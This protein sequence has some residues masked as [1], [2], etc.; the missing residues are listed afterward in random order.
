MESKPKTSKSGLV[1]KINKVKGYDAGGV[2]NPQL[3]AQ[4]KNQKTYQNQNA[5]NAG[6]AL[7]GSVGTFVNAANTPDASGNIS[8]NQ[9]ALGTSLQDASAGAS[10]GASLG[11]FGGPLGTLIGGG[12]G[13]LGGG[14]YGA[15]KGYG[16]ANDANSEAAKLVKEQADA[17]KKTAFNSN[18]ANQFSSRNLYSKGG[19]V[20]GKGTGTSDSIKAKVAPGSFIVPAKNAKKAK[21][22]KE[23]ILG[24]DTD[25]KAELN[26]KN[27]TD[28]RISHGEYV[29]SPEEK[30]ELEANGINL[31]MLAPDAEHEN[32]EMNK[33]G[34]SPEKA[35]LILKD[36]TIRGKSITDKQR[37]YF[38]WV[39]GGKKDGGVIEEYADGG[40]VGD[41]TGTNAQNIKRIKTLRKYKQQ[42]L[43]G[44][45][46]ESPTLVKSAI[47][48][49]DDELNGIYSSYKDYKFN[50]E[51]TYLDEKPQSITS[52]GLVNKVSKTTPTTAQSSL[53]KT[54]VNQETDNSVVVPPIT[55]VTKPTV[56][57]NAIDE[58]GKFDTD[59]AAAEAANPVATKPNYT[60][61]I[62]SGLSSLVN[63]GVPLLQAGLGYKYLK[64]AGPRPVDAIDPNY[65]TVL[66]NANTRAT[67]GFNPEEQAAINNNN[68]NL[69]NAQRFSARNLSGGSAAN[70]YTLERS[71]LNDSFG[72]GL[73]SSVANRDLQLQKR[74][75]ADAI[76]LQK[77][78]LSRRLFGDKM[79]A[80]QQNQ[81]TG[82]LLLGTGLSNLV[83]ANR[84]QQE[85]QSIAD[86]NA[87]YYSWLNS[88][89]Q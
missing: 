72:R 14:I 41:N 48:K 29:F 7:A 43:T 76:A 25:A 49:I 12:I 32:P 71:A 86:Q 1:N 62:G 69:T 35:K 58:A 37:N 39:A 79:S 82:S 74:K 51:P 75:D 78:E 81:N 84:Y 56:G 63:Y 38:G 26:D 4:L 67:Y 50:S 45:N 61:A 73:A 15:I 11:S 89:P 54:L 9:S 13:A 83:G 68:N 77:V 53:A 23:E 36:G 10:L 5:I 31:D 80:F 28:I 44:K 60:R 30:K 47:K 66:N 27:G 17:T 87:A 16:N 21:V 6:S 20:V 2:V 88:L 40:D 59:L 85:K 3:A 33:G 70:A 24:Q 57:A 19:K 52:K 34:L 8:A 18:L 22:I 55:P 46:P 65:Q 42:L 64:D